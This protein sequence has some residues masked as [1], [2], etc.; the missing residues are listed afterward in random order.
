MSITDF[1]SCTQVLDEFESL[2][3]PHDIMQK[4]TSQ[5][6]LRP[7]TRP[8]LG[9]HVRCFQPIA[10]ASSTSSSPSTT[11]WNATQS[12]TTRWTLETRWNTLVT[13]RVL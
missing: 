10:T 4:P 1:L 7:A 13:G 9:L 2:S 3:S 12:Q 11:G 5:V 6:L 8:W